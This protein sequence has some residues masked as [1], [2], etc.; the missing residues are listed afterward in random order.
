MYVG[1]L[2]TVGLVVGLGLMFGVWGFGGLTV[3]YFGCL[4]LRFGWVRLVVLGFVACLR[5]FS[6]YLRLEMVLRNRL[7]TPDFGISALL[8]LW[9][10]GWGFGWCADFLVWWLFECVWVWLFGVVCLLVV[11][12]A[13]FVGF[14][15]LPGYLCLVRGWY[16]IGSCL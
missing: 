2:I 1:Y 8:C 9:V 4:D 11:F 7:L 10:W 12:C 16:N 5:W 6:G 13:V 15:E 3:G 14:G